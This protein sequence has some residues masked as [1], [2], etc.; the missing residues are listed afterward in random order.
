MLVHE[1]FKEFLGYLSAEKNASDM[2][3]S[4]YK[5][6]HKIFCEF[7]ENNGITEFEK[8]T[9]PVLRRYVIFL[10][11]DKKYQNKTIRRKIHSLSS[12]YK[13]LLEQEYIERNPMLPIH[14]PKEEEKLPIY[15]SP[16]E[17]EALIS[18]AWRYGGVNALRNK[19]FIKTLAHTGMRR[20]EA[21]ALDWECVDF[22][23]NTITV[24]SGKGKKDRMLPMTESLATDLWAYLQTRLPLQ[25]HAVFISSTTGQRLTPS[26]SNEIFRRSIR[27]AGLS[28]KKYTPHTLRHTYATML[29]R[30]SDVSYI[31]KLLGHADLS[32]TMIYTHLSMDKLHEQVQKLPFK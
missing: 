27:K 10:K 7:L 12:F 14:A 13:F 4:S 31:Q 29:A 25:C 20:R 21:L 28:G 19:C 32:T 9:T 5:S 24:R 17:V 15:M 2:T 8:I 16:E 22:S 11:A 26:P 18:A 23:K 1:Y 30:N 3:K 6:D